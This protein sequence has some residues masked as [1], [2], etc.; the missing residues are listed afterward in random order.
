MLRRLV[1]RNI[2]GL[3][4]VGLAV[5]AG[6]CSGEVGDPAGG[7]GGAGGGVGGTSGAGGGAGSGGAAGFSIGANGLRRLTRVEYDD[8]LRDLLGDATRPGFAKLPE[9][10]ADPFDNDYRT[11]LVSAALVE[12]VE[13]LAT[14]AAARALA[15]PARRDRLVGCT[16]TGP[17]DA[18]CLRAF[19]T[20][21]GRRAFRRPLRE[22]EITR[23]L[24]FQSFSVEDKSFYTGAEMVVR[25]LLQDPEFVYRV[26]IG[27]PVA[28]APGLFR[29]DGY[30]VGARLAYLVWGTTPGD[31]LLDLAA[32]GA[33][34]T[35][36]GRRAAASMLLGDARAKTRLAR[37][38]ALWLGYHQLPFAADL[39]GALRAES[40]ALIARALFDGKR[41]YFEIF[42]APDTFVNDTLAAHY[43]LPAPANPAGAF[44]SYPM[45][46]RRG[47]LAHGSTLSVGAKF[48]DTS[49]TLRG[50]FVR[51]RLLCE[52]PPVPPPNVDVDAKPEG[53]TS[54]CKEDRYAAH[55]SGGCAGCHARL[56]GIGWG[57][58]S[59]DRAGRFR[60]VERDAPECAIR[61]VGMLHPFGAFKGPAELAK[62]L[63]DAG[64]GAGGAGMEGCVA[65]QL[66]RFA[67]GRRETSE[68]LATI[69]RL[70]AQ[71]TQRRPDFQDLLLDLVSSQA[72]AHRRQED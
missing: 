18:A 29:L 13:T 20:T 49:P 34:R 36:D 71:F 23:Y 6:G 8:T 65:T 2:V 53:G 58:E 45:A 11:Q 31:G 10:A 56:D 1:A 21:F 67:M 61:G 39:A 16:P 69:E 24:A 19:I 7:D 47:I 26:E 68:D 3:V 37:F 38:H 64:A 33:L 72:F 46:D 40:D 28:G 50:M 55:A 44:V 32:G 25:A 9:D 15:D 43:G 17:D 22:E 51:T 12:S 52:E 41:D 70:A 30:E 57:L 62:M 54:R 48:D 60:T 63:V 4:L 59:Y 5:P 27:E 66:Y 14:D 35:V 42:T